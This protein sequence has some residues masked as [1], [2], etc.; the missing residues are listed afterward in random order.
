MTL[1]PAEL[2]KLGLPLAL[3][4]AL[5]AV[6]AALVWWMNGELVR[7]GPQLAA[8]TA[9]RNQSRERLA[10]ISEEER[11]VKDKIEVYQ[12][13]GQA[14]ILGEERRLEWADAIARIRGSREL[15]E[16]RY[17]IEPQKP[18]VS[19]PGKPANVDFYASAMKLDLA[20]LHEG[21]LIA[22]LGDLRD[23]G[24]QYTA[25]QRCNLVR[26]GVSPAA[27]PSL[28]PRLRAQCEVHLITIVDRAA[29]PS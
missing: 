21:D 24:N 27:G 23:S 13:L 25:V 12:Q 6:G 3:A 29:K 11:E 28:A 18:L 8:A 9:E 22:F 20:L 7:S 1:T 10:R 16:L 26:S 19:V 2:R 4:L 15:L 14:G 17:R 5:L